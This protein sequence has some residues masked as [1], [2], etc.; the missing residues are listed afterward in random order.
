MKRPLSFILMALAALSLPGLWCCSS[1]KP[2]EFTEAEKAQQAAERQVDSLAFLTASACLESMNFIIIPSSIQIN[3]QRTHF[4]PDEM[5]NFMC[6]ADGKGI[7]QLASARNPSPGANG[8]GGITTD[9]SIKLTRQRTT[10]KGDRSFE[11]NIQGRASATITV[12]LPKNSTRASVR[13][14]SNL[15]P[16]SINMNGKVV[17]YDVTRVSVGAPL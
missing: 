14:T 11:Y 5:T 12:N 2:T 8:M 9:G 3:G 10:K 17:P 15:Y 1:F 16:G 13:I 4:A 7:I 6:A